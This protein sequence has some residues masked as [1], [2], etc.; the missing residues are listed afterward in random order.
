MTEQQAY[1]AQNALG[2]EGDTFLKKTI[3]DLIKNED[4]QVIIETGTFMGATTL[5]F[6]KMV[7]EV[8]TIEINE[9]YYN[10]AVKKFQNAD[11]EANIYVALDSS[12][13]QL[14]NMLIESSKFGNVLWFCDSHWQAHNPLLE[15][16]EI[17]LQT[18]LKPVICIHDF[19]VPGHP[20]LGFDSYNGQDY[21]LA[22]IQPSIERIY[23]KDGYEYW[24]NSEATGAKRGVV[25]I[26]PKK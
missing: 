21:D 19:K 5:Q 1:L 3:Q 15:E 8:F 23:G 18:G 9:G 24:Y 25:F 14:R 20:E 6:A 11:G 13:N 7:K 2:F 22:W 16:L 26:K 17:L 12:V 10:E 4:I